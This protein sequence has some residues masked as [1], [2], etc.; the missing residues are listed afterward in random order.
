MSCASPTAPAAAAFCPLESGACAEK[1]R[2]ARAISGFCRIVS[3]ALE[4]EESIRLITEQLRRVTVVL[5]QPACVSRVRFASDWHHCARGH[6][7]AS[8]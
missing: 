3:K 8:C 7:D 4:N 6:A 1:P 2:E 5:S